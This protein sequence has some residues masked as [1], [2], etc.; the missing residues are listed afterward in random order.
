[1]FEALL[2]LGKIAGGVAAAVTINE[3]RMEK[4]K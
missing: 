1:M 4:K 3:W 2:F